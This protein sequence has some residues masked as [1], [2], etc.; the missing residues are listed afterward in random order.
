MAVQGQR[1]DRFDA[2]EPDDADQDSPVSLGQ[3]MLSAVSGS[4]ITSLLGESCAASA[5]PSLTPVQSLPSTS[6]A[7]GCRPSSPPL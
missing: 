7:Y 3:K 6:S 1:H 5:N 2:G 4:L